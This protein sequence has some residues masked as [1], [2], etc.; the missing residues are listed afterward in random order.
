MPSSFNSIP[1]P[2]PV[3]TCIHPSSGCGGSFKIDCQS[4]A[5]SN[6]LLFNSF[7]CV[8]IALFKLLVQNVLP[9]LVLTSVPLGQAW[10]F[11]FQQ[12][13]CNFLPPQRPEV[14]RPGYPVPMVVVETPGN[15]SEYRIA[16]V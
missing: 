8:K 6:L 14:S 2:G 16:L 3:G 5:L 15:P 10:F 4:S 9:T 12:V 11:R 7:L 1:Q 13:A